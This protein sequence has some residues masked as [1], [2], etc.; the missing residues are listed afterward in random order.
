[1]AGIWKLVCEL[2]NQLATAHRPTVPPNGERTAIVIITMAVIL[3]DHLLNR[4]GLKIN[5]RLLAW[6]FSVKKSF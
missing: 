2:G 6:S 1:M 3:A 4:W 5:I